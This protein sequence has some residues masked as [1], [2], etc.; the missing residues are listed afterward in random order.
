MEIGDFEKAKKSV[1]AWDPLNQL[2]M[3]H[4]VT[5]VV[6]KS[7]NSKDTQIETNYTVEPYLKS[8][9]ERLSM[10]GSD[11]LLVTGAHSHSPISL[12]LPFH[13]FFSTLF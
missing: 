6:P 13:F 5:S 12:T 1:E 10:T 4:D 7:F 9:Q 8:S 11:T 3:N 2:T